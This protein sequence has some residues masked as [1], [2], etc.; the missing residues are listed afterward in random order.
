VYTLGAWPS[1]FVSLAYGP[2]AFF[3]LLAYLAVM[4]R[5]IMP[6]MAGGESHSRLVGML[7]WLC[8]YW[9]AAW[10]PTQRQMHACR[11]NY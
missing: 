1:I 3:S 7:R 8:L 10:L 6:D 11:C 5:V 4:K 9:V 2:L